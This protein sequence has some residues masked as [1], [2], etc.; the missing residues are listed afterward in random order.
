MVVV[1]GGAVV[2]VVVVVGLGALVVELV[3]V[4]AGDG[5][6]AVAAGRVVAADLG[7]VVAVVVVVVGNCSTGGQ[8]RAKSASVNAWRS[9]GTINSNATVQSWVRLNPSS[10]RP[11]A[12]DCAA[13]RAAASSA[14]FVSRPA[15]RLDTTTD[16]SPAATPSTMITHSRRGRRAVC[17]A[18]TSR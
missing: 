8:I 4:V 6:T 13:P 12:S 5:R 18:S 9:S 2:P 11:F 16:V 1:V 15:D 10:S 17:G 3:A 14:A 7:A